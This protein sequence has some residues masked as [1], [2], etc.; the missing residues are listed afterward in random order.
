[1]TLFIASCATAII[2]SFLCSLMEAVLLSLNPLQWLWVFSAVF[3]V[4]I[5]VATE[6]IPKLIGVAYG[7]RLAP[8]IGAPL[9]F[10]TTALEAA[11]V[12]ERTAFALHPQTTARRNDERDGPPHAGWLGADEPGD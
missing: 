11:G 4:V 1:M 9:A 10:L 6:I 7:E 5:L 3:T 8:W 12:P 2:V